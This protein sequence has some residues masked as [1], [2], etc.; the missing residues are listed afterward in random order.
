MDDILLL[1]SNKKH[2]KKAANELERYLNNTL[3][4]K[5]KPTYQL[6]PLDS[7]PID[8]MGYK[9]YSYKTV[10]RKRIFDRANKVYV[11]MKNPKNEMS[12]GDAYKVVSYYGYFK[13]TYSKKYSKKVKLDKT[14]KKAKEVISNASK[15][16]I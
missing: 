13:H 15:S 5:L 3:G 9:I 2:V 14:V 7:R 8:M 4:L 6:F 12:L 1:G 10:V 16:S 11:K